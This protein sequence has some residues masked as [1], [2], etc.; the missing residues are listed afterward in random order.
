MNV[1]VVRRHV[2]AGALEMLAIADRTV[3]HARLPRRFEG[4]RRQ[5]DDLPVLLEEQLVPLSVDQRNGVRST[6]G[7]RRQRRDAGNRDLERER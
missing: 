7:E 1:A 2:G 4:G 3:A 5:R 6:R